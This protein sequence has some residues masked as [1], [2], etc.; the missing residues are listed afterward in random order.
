MALQKRTVLLHI[1]TTLSTTN[2]IIKKLL[3]GSAALSF[4]YSAQKVL[5]EQQCALN[6]AV[7]AKLA[8]I[9]V[10]GKNVE[11]YNSKF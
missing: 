1:I 7:C 8:D 10:Q 4:T 2:D 3:G 5:E 6:D 11:K 9:I